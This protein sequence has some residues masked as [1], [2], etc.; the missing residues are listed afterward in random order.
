MLAGDFENRLDLWRRKRLDP[1]VHLVAVVLADGPFLLGD[2]DLGCQLELEVD[3]LGDVALGLVEALGDGFLIRW[4]VAI[5]DQPITLGGGSRLDHRDV[6]FALFVPSACDHDLEDRL[7]EVLLGRKRNPLT[8]L[9]GES[10]GPQ[11]AF[12]GERA[13]REGRRRTVQCDDVEGILMVDGQ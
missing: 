9:Q 2:I 1:G 3:H 6:D 10:N 13:D 4:T 11:R 8:L 5:G 12:E 7:I